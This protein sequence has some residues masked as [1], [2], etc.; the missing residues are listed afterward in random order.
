MRNHGVLCVGRDCKTAIARVVAI[1]AE[2][3]LYF[4]GHVSGTLPPF[5]AAL[6]RDALVAEL[7][8]SFR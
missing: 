6:V 8:K 2:C 5:A 1:E 4:G 7:G 3:A